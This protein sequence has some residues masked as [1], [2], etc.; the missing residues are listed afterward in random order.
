MRNLKLIAMFALVAILLV[1][2]A[3]DAAAQRRGGGSSGSSQP[4]PAGFEPYA[5]I[6]AMYGTM[7]GGNID[8]TYSYYGNQSRKLRFGTGPSYTIAL[9]F[10]PHP[11][12]SIEIF[13]TKQDGSL[14]LDY[15]GKRT[16]TNTSH[17]FWHI[18]S[19]RY[20]A[21]PGGVMPYVMMS[22]GATYFSPEETTFLLDEDDPE[23]QV[24]IDSATK[25]SLALGLG[26]KA[27]FGEAQKFGLRASFK[28]LPTFYNTWGGMYFGSG[29]GG[30]SVSGNAIWQWEAAIGLT[31]KMG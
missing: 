3:D 31:L 17:N 29:G 20:L 28:T 21:P 19:V 13:Y 10:N 15:Q 2:L 9:A 23:S 5:E 11:M 4:R 27:Y 22:L 16:L 24:Y 26:V 1:G 6:S 8:I 25:F 12:Q 14:D 7:W 30:V 18:G